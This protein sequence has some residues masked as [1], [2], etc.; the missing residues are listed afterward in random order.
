MPNRT[1]RHLR[2]LPTIKA[3]PAMVRAVATVLALLA[4]FG[5]TWAADVTPEQQALIV[6]ALTIL[7]PLLQGLWTRYAVTAN[8]KVVARVSTSQ[9]AVVAGEAALAPTGSTVYTVTDAND[10]LAVVEL[11]VRP[12]LVA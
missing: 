7:A 8:A 3:E 2:A 11:A 10:D 9:G 6:A 5:L 12:E 4:S 1:R